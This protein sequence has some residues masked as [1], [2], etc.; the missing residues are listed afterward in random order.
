MCPSS[1]QSVSSTP[2]AGN[3]GSIAD[4]TAASMFSN[5]LATSPPKLF[6]ELVPAHAHRFVRR[7]AFPQSTTLVSRFMRRNLLKP[8]HRIHRQRDGFEGFES[9]N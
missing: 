5:E 9:P 3:L 7:R 2:S 8:G 4:F 1:P 6:H